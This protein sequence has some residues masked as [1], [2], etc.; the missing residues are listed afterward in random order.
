MTTPTATPVLQ[1]GSSADKISKS[2]IKSVSAIKKIGLYKTPNFSKKTRITW[3]AKQP[4]TKQP[5]FVVL[6]TARSKSGKLRYKVRDVNHGSKTYG[7]VGYI[8]ANKKYVR[9]TYYQTLTTA[10]HQKTK[11]I[12]ILNPKGVN[13]YKTAARKGKVG[14]YR[15]GQQL[16]VKRIVHYHLTTRIQL[17][18]GRYITANRQWIKTGKVAIHQ[19]HVR[20]QRGVNYRH[21][22]TQRAVQNTST[23]AATP[24]RL[25]GNL[26]WTQY[27]AQA[28]Q[29]IAPTT[30]VGQPA[31]QGPAQVAR[32]LIDGRQRVGLY[33]ATTF[34]SAH[35]L[36][37]LNFQ[38]PLA[39]RPELMVI[40]TALSPDGT[41]RLKVRDINPQSPTF[42]LEGYITADQDYVKVYAASADSQAPLV[43]VPLTLDATTWTYAENGD[44]IYQIAGTY[45]TVYRPV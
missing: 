33:S 4:R 20:V 10:K 25:S 5:Q 1:N 8:T 28:L 17:A 2:P 26:A 14:H 45:V 22:G 30:T 41:L 35:R 11:T 23:Y 15:Q 7:L 19:K 34:T 31:G 43:N 18:N 39:E 13:A 9:N 3:Y 32:L 21:A 27:S 24:S 40:G 44:V 16:K 38:G 6:G 42:G 36:A 12:T 37:W 29:R